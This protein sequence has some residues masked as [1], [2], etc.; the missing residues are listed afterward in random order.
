MEWIFSNWYWVA[1]VIF[2]A[3]LLLS[4][5]KASTP[6]QPKSSSDFSPEEKALLVMV[7]DGLESVLEQIVGKRFG[8]EDRIKIAAGMIA[9]MATMDLPLGKL[10]DDQFFKEMAKISI[11][12]LHNSGNLAAV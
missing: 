10:S 12:Y 11:K 9:I 1:G 8:K 4:G 5:K 2:V 3:A 7:V 6:V